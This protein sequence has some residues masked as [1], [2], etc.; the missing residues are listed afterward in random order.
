M[1]IEIEIK[2]EDFINLVAKEYAQ[3]L[4]D[5][6]NLG[7]FGAV[8]KVKKIVQKRALKL[9]EESGGTIDE[10]IKET[11][12]DEE[13]IREIVERTVKEKVRDFLESKKE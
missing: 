5:K 1:K 4:Y 8:D 6:T 3:K 11:L 13:L 2:K 12:K 10:M 9:L 7:F